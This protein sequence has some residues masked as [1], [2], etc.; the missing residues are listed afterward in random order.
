MDGKYS[1]AHSLVAI[2]GFE[3]GLEVLADL[4]QKQKC[5]SLGVISLGECQ[6]ANAIVDQIAGKINITFCVCLKS[7]ELTEKYTDL[8]QYSFSLLNE[9]SFF[10]KVVL[11]EQKHDT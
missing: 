4:L 10:S 3:I 2:L 1:V 7:D 9:D 6:I 11:P 8:T 5:Q